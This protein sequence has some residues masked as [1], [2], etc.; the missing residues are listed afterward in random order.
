MTN[1]DST[2]GLKQSDLRIYS[3][4]NAAVFRKTKEKWGGLSNMAAGYPININ[5]IKIRTSEALYQ[6]CRYPH[7]PDVQELIISQRS[8]MTAKMRSKP[9]RSQTRPGW[10]KLR[11]AA[12]RWCL[13]AKLLQN[14]EKFGNLLRETGERDIVEEGVKD[15]FWSARPQEDGSLVGYNVLGRLLMELRQILNERPDSLRELSPLNVRDFLLLRIEV[16]M[17]RLNDHGVI[18][19]DTTQFERERSSNIH[20][21]IR[22]DTHD[23]EK[24]DLF[25]PLRLKIG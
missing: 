1:H 20:P 10:E 4:K 8:P 24:V 17:M 6:C 2:A 12:M 5:G 25:A 18:E 11:V 13:R 3:R 15:P 9:Y 7:L 19:F 16:P 22:F 14:W 23:F 21:P